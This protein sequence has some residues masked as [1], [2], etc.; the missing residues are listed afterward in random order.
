M[1]LLLLLT[2]GLLADVQPVDFIT[3]VNSVVVK[4][5]SKPAL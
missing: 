2:S 5:P 1:R 4:P 3:I